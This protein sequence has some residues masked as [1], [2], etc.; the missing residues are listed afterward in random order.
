[1]LPFRLPYAL[2]A[3]G[4]A[5]AYE[6]MRT[7]GWRGRGREEDGDGEKG[8]SVRH[9]GR[10]AIPIIESPSYNRLNFIKN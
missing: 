9:E 10:M 1:M 2:A 8:D 4:G 3:A 6:A 7:E 5:D